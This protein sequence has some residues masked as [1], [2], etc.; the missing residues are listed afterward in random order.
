MVRGIWGL[1]ARGG[2]GDVALHPDAGGGGSAPASSGLSGGRGGA[3][4]TVPVPVLSPEQWE[5]LT[6]E[7]AAKVAARLAV[8]PRYVPPALTLEQY[9]NGEGGETARELFEV[10]YVGRIRRAHEI[11]RVGG[12]TPEA[13][14]RWR[15]AIE[16][17]LK[18]EPI[19]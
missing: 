6:E 2:V 19:D 11:Y 7:A 4:S 1:G 16:A 14:R 8:P 5:E 10:E 12:G 15:A 3:A 17:S 18:R 13:R 9:V